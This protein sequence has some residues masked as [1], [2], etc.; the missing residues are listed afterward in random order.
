MIIELQGHGGVGK[1]TIARILAERLGAR[2]LDNHTIYNPAF[3]VTDFRSPAFYE[4][5]RLVRTVAFGRAADLPAD[6]PVILTI[7]PGLNRE[8]GREWQAAAR[9]LADRRG[10]PLLA[11]HLACSPEE[12]RRRIAS[13]E[14]ALLRKATDGA[15]V[16]TGPDRPALLDHADAV[17]ELDVTSLRAEA[18]ADAIADWVRGR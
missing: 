11:V 4:T 13:P 9:A 18:A 5:V 8:W 6:V 15:L 10:V 2:L 3:A 1:A 17:L 12:N 7:A 16:D 14:R